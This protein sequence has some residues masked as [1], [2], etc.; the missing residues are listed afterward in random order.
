MDLK[1]DS[2][3]DLDITNNK[4]S[5]VDGIDYIAQSWKIRCLTI[6]GEWFLDQRVG[7]PYFEHIFV[8][9]PNEGLIREIFRQATYSVS[10]IKEI[11][12]LELDFDAATRE[13]TATIKGVTE[14]LTTFKFS[15][16]EM[17]I[18]TQGVAA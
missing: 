16:T 10:G 14:D 1:L 13:A 9:G 11:T 5:F 7:I 15:F 8:K 12:S 17:V 6:L 4:F 18:S 2:T 3:G